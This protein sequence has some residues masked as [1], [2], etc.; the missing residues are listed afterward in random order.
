MDIH[1]TTGKRNNNL[2]SVENKAILADGQ[3]EFQTTQTSPRVN[4]YDCT[5]NQSTYNQ[6]AGIVGTID[7]PT[8]IADANAEPVEGRMNVYIENGSLKILAQS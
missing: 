3:T 1:I 4:H 5:C 2:L 7:A 8:L 6:I